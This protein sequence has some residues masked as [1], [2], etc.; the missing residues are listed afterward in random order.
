MIR[1]TINYYLGGDYGE[2]FIISEDISVGKLK[3][4][5]Y[6]A[7][8]PYAFELGN[9]CKDEVALSDIIFCLSDVD[10]PDLKDDDK[11]LDKCTDYIIGRQL[12]LRAVFP[13]PK[14]KIKDIDAIKPITLEE[15]AKKRELFFSGPKKGQ[16]T[17]KIEGMDDIENESR[18]KK[19]LKLLNK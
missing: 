18:I 14:K 13:T 3:E 15:M 7:I 4:S 2:S 8:T 6:K 16:D 9:L 5:F 1:V 11:V 17:N 19:F 10:A 12:N